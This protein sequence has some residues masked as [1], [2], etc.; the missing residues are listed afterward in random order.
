MRTHRRIVITALLVAAG[1]V[2]GA[3][4]PADE[5][6]EAADEA[7][8]TAEPA[9]SATD[10][11]DTAG[12][13]TAASGDTN[14]DTAGGDTDT[15]S[16]GDN[17]G[18]AGDTTAEAEVDAAVTTMLENLAV[19]YRSTA[20]VWPGF[21]PMEHPTVVALRDGSA[22]TGAVAIN[23]PDPKALGTAAPIDTGDAPF[24][25]HFVSELVDAGAL[26]RVAAFE[27]NS[28]QGGVDSFVM[29]ADP[30]DSFLDPEAPEFATTYIHEMFHRY[31]FASFNES[32]FQDFENYPYTAA[33]LEL[34]ALEGRALTEALRAETDQARD[35]AAERFVAIRMA[36]RAAAPEVA[37]LDD[38]QE[39]S[40]GSARYIEHRVA[41][42]DFGA[43]Y[44][45]GNVDSGEIPTDVST[46]FGVK[47]TFGFGRFYA[48]GAAVLDLLERMGVPDYAARVEADEPPATILADALGVTD[49]DVDDLVAAAR[50]NYDPLNELAEQ[51]AAGAT[52]AAE[53]PPIFSDEP[54]D[55]A[56][57]DGS[58]GAE[59][60][61]GDGEY[62]EITDEQLACLEDRGVD[63]A[64]ENAPITD[65]D[66]AA[67]VG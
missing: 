24:T 37:R 1:L 48:T 16:D 60:A 56:G 47:E 57:G 66:F 31:Q 65:A 35:E 44:H 18:D 55:T 29:V 6:N 62:V 4:V 26:E 52:A 59:G 49:A 7:T 40:E 32:R 28:M 30:T 41:S 38:G 5:R 36:R 67:C 46:Q 34:A 23:H 10:G 25:A 22:V 14:T 21:D 58:D 2:A 51:A 64:D 39:I 63:L 9:N 33:N 13:D 11:S 12:S 50:T 27:F 45:Q 19:L 53:E 54:D 3:C 15:E 20:G 61:A 17:D 8:A 43:A 42:E